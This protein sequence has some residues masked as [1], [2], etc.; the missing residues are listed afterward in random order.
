MGKWMKIRHF[1]RK[2]GI[3]WIFTATPWFFFTNFMGVYWGYD[4]KLMV[5]WC[6]LRL[7][8]PIHARTR[9][10]H[11]SGFTRNQQWI[12]ENDMI[13]VDSTSI[14]VDSKRCNYHGPMYYS[15][16][17]SGV[18]WNIATI[19]MWIWVMSLVPWDLSGLD[20]QVRS[21]EHVWYPLVI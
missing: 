1:M 6:R 21:I 12:M 3:D 2:G 4:G 14:M 15:W 10:I 5:M 20:D 18:S 8:V 7:P 17:C 13:M 16:W 9:P 19:T 11:Y